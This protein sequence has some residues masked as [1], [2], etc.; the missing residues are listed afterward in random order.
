MC[1][2]V[3]FLP[4]ELQTSLPSVDQMIAGQNYLLPAGF[5]GF[6]GVGVPSDR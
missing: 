1:R 4:A 5:L 6:Q 3:E 2:L